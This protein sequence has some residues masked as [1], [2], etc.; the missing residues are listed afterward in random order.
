M[1]IKILVKDGSENCVVGLSGITQDN[2]VSALEETRN[3][4]VKM[5]NYGN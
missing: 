1:E 4:I 5:Q 3:Y 2:L